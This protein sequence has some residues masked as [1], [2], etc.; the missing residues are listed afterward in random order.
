[1]TRA[2]FFLILLTA[3]KGEESGDT[4][5]TLVEATSLLCPVPGALPFT[6]D[7]ASFDSAD[8][9][10]LAEDNPREKYEPADVFGLPDGAIAFTNMDQSSDPAAG[11][12]AARGAMGRTTI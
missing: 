2:L 11:D 8:N 1:M 6:T 12:F 5:P 9:E 4:D 3:C 7:A 10:Y